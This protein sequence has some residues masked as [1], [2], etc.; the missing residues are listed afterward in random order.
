M[1]LI[2]IIIPIYN[3]ADSLEQC[4]N[5]IIQQSDD[6][7]QIVLVDDGSTDDSLSICRKLERDNESIVVI[8]QDNQGSGPAR[9]AG[10]SEAKGKYFLFMDSDDTLKS[11]SLSQMCRMVET[12]P[13]DV[14]VFGYEIISPSGKVSTKSFEN[15]TILGSEIRSDYCPYFSNQFKWAIQ[16]AP[17]NKL[18][19]SQVVHLNGIKF[20]D[21]RRHQ[22]EV[23]I[24]RVMKCVETVSFKDVVLYTHYANDASKVWR[25]FPSNYFS[26]VNDLYKYRQE[27]VEEFNPSNNALKALTYSEYIN[28]SFRAGFKLFDEKNKKQMADRIVYY[29]EMREGFIFRQVK[30]PSEYVGTLKRIQNKLYVFSLAGR[31][32]LL[33]DLLVRLR[34]YLFRRS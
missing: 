15:K 12:N 20:P 16:G 6:R 32:F 1:T 28:N 24:S 34:L 17:W 18:F 23:F 33:F 19:K 26:I 9:N 11:N 4:V 30:Y 7:I 27:I 13:T 14:I 22:D 5:S 29:R 3:M 21:L 31:H 25:K 2:S 8:H 10:I